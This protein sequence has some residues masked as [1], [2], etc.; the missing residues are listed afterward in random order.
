VGNILVCVILISTNLHEINS[1]SSISALIVGKTRR[2][3]LLVRKSYRQHSEP[4]G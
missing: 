3:V 2:A 4:Q 1:H